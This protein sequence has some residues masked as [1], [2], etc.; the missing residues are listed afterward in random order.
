MVDDLIPYYQERMRNL[1]SPLQR[2]LVD[3]LC[4]QRKP[5]PVKDIARATLVQPQSAAKQ[6]GELARLAIVQRTPRGRESYYELSEPLM[7]ICIEVKDNRTEYIRTFVDLLRYWFSSRELE[8]IASARRDI[9][10][11]IDTDTDGILSADILL[12][13]LWNELECHGPV[14]FATQTVAIH[15]ELP[16]TKNAL[17]LE[18]LLSL[19]RRIVRTRPSFSGSAGWDAA[20]ETLS[21]LPRMDLLLQLFRVG[22]RF[23]A[24]NDEGVLLELPLEQRRLIKYEAGESMQ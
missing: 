5:S 23:A 20:F 7:R 1:T 8:G 13:S 22:V 24:T 6:L 17:V 11:R 12:A 21:S 19:L 18:A 4:R 14:S 16:A 3:Y 2:K 15:G 9:A 10:A